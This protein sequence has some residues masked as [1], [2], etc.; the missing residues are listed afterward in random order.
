MSEVHIYTGPVYLDHTE[1]IV[2][3]TQSDLLSGK[4]VDFLLPSVRHIRKLKTALLT[5]LETTLP[6]QLYFGTFFAWANRILDLVHQSYKIISQGEE[7]FLLYLFFQKNP[8]AFGALKPGSVA[9]L[10]QILIDLR[11]SGFSISQLE[12]LSKNVS[13]PHFSSYL[14]ILRHLEQYSFEKRIATTVQLLHQACDILERHKVEHVGD[15]LVVDGFYEFNPV[16]KRMLKRL[17]PKYEQVVIY[18]PGK[19]DHPTLEYL[20]PI[21]KMFDDFPCIVTVLQDQT[22]TYFNELAG[23]FFRNTFKSEQS[24]QE[25]EPVEWKNNYDSRNV[26]IVRCPNRRTEI[27]I[28]ARTIKQWIAEGFSPDRIAVISRGSYDYTSLIQL[29]FPRFGIPV[30]EA[31]QKLVNTVPVRLIHKI[32]E[33][34]EKSFSRDSI[35]DLTRFRDIRNYYGSEIIQKFEYKSSA[36]GLSFSKDSWIDQLK[37]RKEYLE[38]ILSS[39][40]EN[41]KDLGVFERELREI[42]QIGPVISQFLRDITLPEKA[43][44][45]EYTEKNIELLSRYCKTKNS[46]DSYTE[47]IKNI[48]MI[49]RKLEVM[50]DSGSVVQLRYFSMVFNMMAAN[51]IVEP[52]VRQM[53]SG[54]V[55]TDVMNAR[56]EQFD[57]VILLG[58]VDGDFPMQRRENPI[59]HNRQRDEINRQ[60]GENIFQHTGANIAE[61]KFLFY[62]LINQVNKRLL[63]TFPQFDS[64]GHVFSESPFLDEL[65]GFADHSEECNQISYESVSAATVIPALD[66]AASVADIQLNMFYRK[67]GSK[68]RKFFNN[69]ID[70]SITG[71][72]NRK[73]DIETLR[74]KNEPCEW[75]GQMSLSRTPDECF[76]RRL[77]ITRLQQYAWCPFLY[78]CQNVW[79]IDTV[80]EPLAELSPLSDGVLI[81]A[82][83]EYV[84]KHADR[85][86]FEQWQNYI[87]RDL[88]R[89]IDNTVAYINNRFRT[90]FGFIEDALWQKKLSDLKKGLELFIERERNSLDSG[91]FPR[92]LEQVFHFDLSVNPSDSDDSQNTVSFQAKIDRID[93]NRDGN[94]IIIEYKR[95][96]SSV[97][98]P[99]K[100]VEDGIHFQ[101][102]FYLTVTRKNRKDTDLGGAYSYVFYEGKLAKGVFTKPY[103]KR[104]AEISSS[105]LELLLEQTEIKIAEMLNQICQGNFMLKPHDVTK[106]CKHGKCDYYE[107]CRIDNRLREL[108]ENDD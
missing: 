72:I 26:K 19:N 23:S 79:K 2:D 1:H 95:S 85:D 46:T 107:L 22:T 92:E 101:I 94:I 33:I 97:Q 18:A 81:H 34:N 52:S 13:S 58:M 96:R 78:L 69:L 37:R 14:S 43:H 88:R 53:D 44:W 87:N 98:D 68:D 74:R 28:A 10:Q 3:T 66:N 71:E 49:C 27:D 7:W 47:S 108:S 84:L 31:G 6:G 20:D 64:G 106:R 29:L 75:N 61:E 30:A 86:S 62:H 102:P 60:A 16:Q 38:T 105:E 91:F 42:H 4:K 99:V 63:I 5:S 93:Q 76:K 54:V 41:E 35:I 8:K 17:V 15:L 77:S 39:D 48:E 59:L 32:I 83:F 36:W 9:L 55:I 50:G 11:E 104:T 103:F 90:T 57:A 89:E 70:A 12:S 24:F 80:E 25:R 56:S 21:S 67:W 65:M 73:I 40:V 51:I 45:A 100:G 82:L